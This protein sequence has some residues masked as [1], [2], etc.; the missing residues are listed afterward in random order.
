MGSVIM[1]CD[2]R[3]AAAKEQRIGVTIRYVKGK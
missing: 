1:E 3:G 2:V